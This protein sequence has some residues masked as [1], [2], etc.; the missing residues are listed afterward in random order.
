LGRAQAGE[1]EAIKNFRALGLNVA[2]LGKLDP[3]AAFSRIIGAISKTENQFDRAAFAASIFGRAAVDLIPILTATR[4]GFAALISEGFALSGALGTRGVQSIAALSDQLSKLKLLIS[5]NATALLEEMSPALIQIAEQWQRWLT[6]TIAGVSLVGNAITGLVDTFV[7]FGQILEVGIRDLYSG[8][9]TI[10]S[11][12]AKVAKTFAGIPLLGRIVG[13]PEE[14]QAGIDRN[15]ERIRQNAFQA[16]AVAGESFVGRLREERERIRNR[17]V[18]LPAPQVPVFGEPGFDREEDGGSPLS[19]ATGTRD[20]L[21]GIVT[22]LRG[23]RRDVSLNAG[24][25]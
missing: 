15:T 14:F 6:P 5:A 2:E 22:E 3:L 9:L 20:L 7:G 16:N 11:A 19:S 25:A 1:K 23:L 4:G 8:F 17:G 10:D 12:V 24:L 13:T 18:P 21:S